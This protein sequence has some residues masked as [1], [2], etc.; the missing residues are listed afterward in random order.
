[1]RIGDYVIK[2]PDG[3]SVS[4]RD[5]PAIGEI[6]GRRCFDI[7]KGDSTLIISLWKEMNPSDL[8]DSLDPLQHRIFSISD[9]E[10]NGVR[11]RSWSYSS[12]YGGIS[13]QW[14]IKSGEAML[15]LSLE[16]KEWRSSHYAELQSAVMTLSYEPETER[17]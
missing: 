2:L 1:M 7:K 6:E 12:I 9:V 13:A 14:W 3:C 10:I 17:A 11:G 16:G 15:M 8:D 4:Q 5:I